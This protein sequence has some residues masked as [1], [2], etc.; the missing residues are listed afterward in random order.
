[1]K[2]FLGAGALYIFLVKSS[3][4]KTYRAYSERAPLRPTPDLVFGPA[5]RGGIRVGLS[6]SV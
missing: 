1:M 5:P 6:L 3:E 4:E 2:A